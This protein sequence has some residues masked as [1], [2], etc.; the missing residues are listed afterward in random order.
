[1]RAENDSCCQERLC[2]CSSLHPSLSFSSISSSFSGFQGSGKG[3]VKSRVTDLEL[4]PSL[5]PASGLSSP[6]VI[7]SLC[8]C[9]ELVLL[10]GAALT[11]LYKRFPGRANERTC[12]RRG[13]SDFLTPN[14]CM[15]TGMIASD[16]SQSCA[17]QTHHIPV[18]C[19]LLF[20]PGQLQS[21]SD[22]Y[23]RILLP[24]SKTRH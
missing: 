24:A 6:V 14:K 20:S 7:R 17:L 9:L 23:C 5:L 22:R 3:K 15:Q 16:Y 11:V 10:C 4:A 8:P 13:I 19:C 2:P 18:S 21:L 12:Q 1:M